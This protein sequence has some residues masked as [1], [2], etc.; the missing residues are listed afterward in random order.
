[1]DAPGIEDPADA[2]DAIGS[3]PTVRLRLLGPD[4]EVVDAEARTRIVRPTDDDYRALWAQLPDA[5]RAWHPSWGFHPDDDPDSYPP[6]A[7]F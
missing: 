7:V 1:V 3:E 4:I 5:D 6:D 2:G